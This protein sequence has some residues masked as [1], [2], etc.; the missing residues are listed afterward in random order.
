MGRFVGM[1]AILFG[2]FGCGGSD[3]AATPADF[4]PCGGDIVGVWDLTD[5]VVEVQELMDCPEAEFTSNSTVDGT[6]DFKEDMTYTVDF[7]MTMEPVLVAPGEC[8]PSAFSDCTDL[9]LI[10]LGT[11]SCTG[12]ISVE[13]TCVFDP[14]TEDVV[15]NGTWTVDGEQVILT[16]DGSNNPETIDFCAGSNYLQFNHW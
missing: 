7:T 12:D 10:F 1:V 8:I 16:E 5:L 13:C 9:N 3:L 14:Q 2:S 15:T 4:D 11:A 6:V